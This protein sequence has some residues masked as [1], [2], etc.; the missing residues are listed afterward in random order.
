MKS[1]I[2]G[3]DRKKTKSPKKHAM[4]NSKTCSNS[5]RFDYI[6]AGRQAAVMRLDIFSD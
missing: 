5:I 1:Y 2:N 4:H 3:S 6:N